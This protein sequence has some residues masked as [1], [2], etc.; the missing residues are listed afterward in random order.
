MIIMIENVEF[1]F[2]HV[3]IQGIAQVGDWRKIWKKLKRN[4]GKKR[5]TT[6]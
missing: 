5:R 3:K 2:D 1:C 4:Q 6:N